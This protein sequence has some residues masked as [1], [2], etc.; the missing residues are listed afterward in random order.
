MKS[1]KYSTFCL[2][3]FGKLFSWYNK[4]PL[5]EKNMFLVK[6]DIYLSYEEY[7]S[8]A[9]MN[10]II[11]FIISLF[12]SY[13]FYS[14][15]PSD[16]TLFILF[17]LPL[18]VIFCIILSYRN[19]PSYKIKRRALNIDLFLPYAINFV[20]S[21]AVAG[22]SPAEIFET[23]SKISVY[24]EVQ[25]EAK[26]INKEIK[27]MGM[28]N[29]TALKHA[30]EVSPSRKFKAFLQGIIGT[31]QSGSDLHLYLSHVADKYMDDDLVDRK[32]DLDLLAVIAE[33]L[34]LAVIAFPIFLVII[35]TVMG[36][37][38]GSMEVSLTLLLLF[39][40]I[41]LP[42]VYSMFYL[43]IKSTSVEQLR[44]V[45]PNK[46]LT[47][48]DYYSENKTPIF[49]FLIS[50]SSVVILYLLIV[51]L[52]YIGYLNLDLYL[53]W[54]FSFISLL[55]FITP[56]G[57]Y[58]YLKM[59]EKKEMQERFPEFLTD[60]GDSLSTGRNIFDSIKTA[61]KGHFGKLSPEIH[62]IKSQ[63]SW[64]V[65]MKNALFDFAERMKSA[66][67]QRIVIVVDKGLMMGGNTPKIFKAAAKEVDQVNQVEYQRRSIMSIYALVMVVC[68]FVFLAIIMILNGTV[69][70]TFFDIQTQQAHSAAGAI[71]LSPVDPTRLHYTLLSFTFIQSIGAGI[72]AGFMMD[73]KI[74]SGVRYS[75]A[76]AVITIII[77][78]TLI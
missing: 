40:F 43:L 20:S 54:D 56:L 63:L 77:F 49:I 50:V 73:G 70:N 21:M 3:R 48:R 52:D 55:I 58:N 17:G 65:S 5:D 53:F 10:T 28:D 59:L 11:G 23:I 60:V 62:K 14:L 33:V 24:G 30:I 45:G 31:I 74:S 75:C 36:F 34:V 76:L 2:R 38:G 7:F 4:K 6:A 29:I 67:F 51:L 44:K 72:L 68:F 26:K 71:R 25:V 57:V 64:N 46:N 18:L 61:A 1:T 66:I 27:A 15:F 37:F 12:F 42:V 22:I 13:L 8:T 41:I 19:Y 32:K 39:S 69:Y 47:V 35:L 78:K 9:T 16:F